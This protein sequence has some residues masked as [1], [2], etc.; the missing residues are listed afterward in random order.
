MFRFFSIT[1]PKRRRIT[2]RGLEGLEA[3]TLLSAGHHTAAISPADTP[4]GN[5]SGSWE[6]VD[7]TGRLDL[8]QEGNK[9]MG[10]F[11]GSSNVNVNVTGKVSGNTMAIHGKGEVSGIKEHFKGHVT[12]TTP[13]HMEGPTKV[14][15][16]GSPVVNYVFS[17]DK[18]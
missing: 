9:V 13:T 2:V 6:F 8:T 17:L 5:F 4:P 1:S 10:N 18:L 15:Q 7:K 16:Q 11:G 3:R 12:L 14:K